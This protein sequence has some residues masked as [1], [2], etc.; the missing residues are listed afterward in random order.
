MTRQKIV[1]VTVVLL[2][3]LLACTARPAPTP[4]ATVTPEVITTRLLAEMWGTLTLDGECLRVGDYLLAWPPDFTVSI[5]GD[6]VSVTDDF[7]HES[8]VWHLGE[9]VTLGGGQTGLQYLTDEVRQRLPAGCAGPYW[10]VG[11]W[12][13]PTP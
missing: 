7:F 12:L 13:T 8:V 1:F 9:T 5:D 3:A 10:L 4:A 6:V 2:A 11:G